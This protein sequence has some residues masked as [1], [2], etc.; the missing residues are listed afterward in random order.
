MK[1]EPKSVNRKNLM[2]AYSR[3][4]PPQMPIKK[5][6]GISMNSKNM[7]N[8]RVSIAT[9]VP[10]MAPLR[11]SNRIKYPFTFCLIL[12]EAIDAM[13]RTIADRKIKGR[14]TPSIPTQ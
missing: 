7:K 8:R 1:M 4:G 11:I 3:L 5:Y 2:D 10:I 9:N 14:L 6:K 13:I 12:E